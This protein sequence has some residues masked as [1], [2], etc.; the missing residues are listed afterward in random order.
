[1]WRGLDVQ[2]S[3]KKVLDR[4]AMPARKPPPR[5]L[6]ALLQ[7]NCCGISHHYTVKMTQDRVCPLHR[8]CEKFTRFCSPSNAFSG[9]NHLGRP[10]AAC[11]AARPG[12]RGVRRALRP[13]RK[14]INVKHPA[15]TGKPSGGRGIML[16]KK[17]LLCEEKIEPKF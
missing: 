3:E 13:A 12:G 14:A 10:D 5:R 9:S 7:V 2:L 15:K 17:A 16:A 8:F 6:V 4:D 1:L 11:F